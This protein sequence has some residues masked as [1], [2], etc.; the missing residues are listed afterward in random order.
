MDGQDPADILMGNVDEEESSVVVHGTV[1]L[2][3][4][5]ERR[6]RTL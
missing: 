1:I 4:I 6:G 3:S 2:G 5:R